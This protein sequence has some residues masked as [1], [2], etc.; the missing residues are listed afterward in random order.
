MVQCY[1]TAQAERNAER[2]K[3][4]SLEKNINK[5]N[6]LISLPV[7]DQ[8]IFKVLINFKSCSS[9][10]P[11]FHEQRGYFQSLFALIFS[12]WPYTFKY[13]LRFFRKPDIAQI[14]ILATLCTVIS[15]DTATMTVNS[16]R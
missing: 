1:F 13:F 12:L 8:S 10:P 3:Q 16:H 6:T 15:K 4:V 11:C 7:P 9:S 5:Y 2:R 14:N